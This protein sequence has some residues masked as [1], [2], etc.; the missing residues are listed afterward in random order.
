MGALHACSWQ[1]RTGAGTLLAL[2]TMLPPPPSYEHPVSG[3]QCVHTLP[4]KKSGTQA[5]AQLIVQW[6]PQGAGAAWHAG[7]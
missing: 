4:I 3:M 6:Y 7:W 5:V 2:C 1:P